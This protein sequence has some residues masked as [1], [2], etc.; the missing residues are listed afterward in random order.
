MSL[1]DAQR[2]RLLDALEDWRKAEKAYGDEAAKHAGAPPEDQWPMPVVT[3][4]A[5]E[6]LTRLRVA[7]DKAR[8]AYYELAASFGESPP[9]T[10]RPPLA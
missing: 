9:P 2:A 3:P 4:E 5:E 1:S 8:A 10:R 6:T 7:A